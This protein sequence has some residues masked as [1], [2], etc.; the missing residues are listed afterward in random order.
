MLTAA[1]ATVPSMA[2]NWTRAMR[3]N[4]RIVVVLETDLKA[5]ASVFFYTQKRVAVRYFELLAPRC[6]LY[7]HMSLQ[8]KVDYPECHHDISSF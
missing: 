4:W 6:R 1:P 3:E 2:A 8:A 5:S 7:S